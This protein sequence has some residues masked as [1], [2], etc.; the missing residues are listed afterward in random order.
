[1]FL[2]ETMADDADADLSADLDS[3]SAGKKGGGKGLIAGALKW[4]LIA[5]AAVILIVT[6]VVIS[7]GGSSSN[8]NNDNP[9]IVYDDST[10]VVGDNNSGYIVVPNDWIKF[11]DEDNPIENGYQYSDI[12]SDYIIT[13]STI[14]ITKDEYKNILLQSL[15]GSSSV[16]SSS[17]K[18]LNYDAE[19]ISAYVEASKSWISAIFFNTEDGKLHFIGI[20][21]PDIDNEF[22]N[23]T[24]SYKLQK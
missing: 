4:I 18:F 11:I 22:F 9:Q 19:Q 10:K 8:E 6:I 23:I 15:S 12:D 14:N 16:N 3:G 1:V 2:E 24:N 17:T 5:V 20:E 13:V 21:G 7:S